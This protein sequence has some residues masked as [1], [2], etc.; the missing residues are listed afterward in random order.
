M[1]PQERRWPEWQQPAGCAAAR[2]SDEER[3]GRITRSKQLAGRRLTGRDSLAQARHS[4]VSVV[5]DS[6]SGPVSRTDSATA[7]AASGNTNTSTTAARKAG[8]H[9]NGGNCRR[10][11]RMGTGGGDPWEA[12]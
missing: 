7:G 2:Q 8:V 11:G 12:K 9:P 6:F 10:S 3:G 1:I 4:C 5:V